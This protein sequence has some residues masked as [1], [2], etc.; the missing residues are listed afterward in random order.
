MTKE[1]K[2]SKQR[3]RDI[4]VSEFRVPTPAVSVQV[5]SRALRKELGVSHEDI[6]LTYEEEMF[7]IEYLKDFDF[8]RTLRRLG[9]NQNGGFDM[10]KLPRV[11]KKM[12]LIMAKRREEAEVGTADILGF[13][14]DIIK[15]P[16]HDIVEH[17][18]G[19]CRYC[20]G[21]DPKNPRKPTYE[22]QYASKAERI[23][24]RAEHSRLR[25]AGIT[26]TRKGIHVPAKF[27]NGGLGY[28]PLRMPNP[29]CPTCRGSGVSN[30]LI[31]DTNSA[32]VRAR[33]LVK[34]IK[35][36]NASGGVSIELHDKL[37][38]TELLMRYHGMFNKDLSGATGPTRI[39]I[40]GG[41]PYDK[42]DVETA[43]AAIAKVRE[44]QNKI[45]SGRKGAA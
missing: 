19:C 41:L 16:L 38:A 31:K 22:Y 13:L 36:D 44:E 35:F 32:N 23:A 25:E 5:G 30:V 1:Q 34:N 45:T 18:L 2:D 33:A 4:P 39:E 42:E 7:I 26:V 21:H 8:P 37:K 24:A 14:G 12:D 15:A 17:V 27:P 10:L 43:K 9:L 40:I 29:K 3:H 20:W 28:D 11:R 6:P